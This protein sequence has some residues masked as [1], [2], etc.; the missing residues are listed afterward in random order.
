MFAQNPNKQASPD[1]PIH[2]LLV[3]RWSPYGFSDQTVSDAD[4]RSL[5]EAARWAAS[6]YN[7]QP[8]RFI[9]ARQSDPDAFKKLLGC[10]V[11]PNQAWAQAVPALALGIARLQFE[12]NGNAN[13]VAL[14]DLGLAAASMSFEATARGLSVHQMSGIL[15][16]LAREQ[17]GIPPEFTAVTALAIGHAADPQTLPDGLRDRDTAPRSRRSLPEFV[18]GET[19][20]EAAG[21]LD[22]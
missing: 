13:S 18:F 6:A 20:G 9:A 7:E 5:F 15:P 3:A 10:L 22:E 14:H 17:Y 19:W 16:D 12:R 21:F 4:L 2:E 8:W 11:E 1:H